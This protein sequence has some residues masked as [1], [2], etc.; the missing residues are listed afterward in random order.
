[1]LAYLV[2]G[3]FLGPNGFAAVTEAESIETISELG[4]IFLL[5]MIGLE[6]DLKKIISAGKSITLTALSQILGGCLLGVVVFRLLGFPLG[7]GKWDALYLAV[8]AAMSSTVISLHGARLHPQGN[9]KHQT[10]ATA[11]GAQSNRQNH[12]SS[13]VAIRCAAIV[14]RRRRLR[15]GRPPS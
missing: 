3:F 12:C 2:A 15:H 8:A 4:L 14:P 9:F 11:S 10:R 13:G 1:M 5:F 6:I 7:G